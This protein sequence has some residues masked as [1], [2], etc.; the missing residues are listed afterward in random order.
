MTFPK[1]VAALLTKSVSESSLSEEGE[2]DLEDNE[3]HEDTEED[4]STV[5]LD[6]YTVIPSQA[7][8]MTGQEEEE[9]AAAQVSDS[10]MWCRGCID[11][12]S[13]TITW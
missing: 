12:H 6:S 8:L 5:D 9:A 7:K 1:P 2:S 3:K 10:L 11:A 4:T 13:H